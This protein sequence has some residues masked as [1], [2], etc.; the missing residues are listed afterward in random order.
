MTLRL[1]AASGGG[2]DDLPH[3][4]AA[5][6][7]QLIPKQRPMV[8]PPLI[9]STFGVRPNSPTTASRI[10]FSGPGRRG[11]PGILKV[12]GQVPERT[13]AFPLQSSRA[14]RWSVGI[15]ASIPDVDQPRPPPPAG[16]TA[17]SPQ[18][19]L[20]LAVPFAD[21][22][23][24]RD[25]SRPPARCPESNPARPSNS[26]GRSSCALVDPAILVVHHGQGGMDRR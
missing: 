9:R 23:V 25:G 7:Q 16:E 8:A 5:A 19:F 21:F 22:G 6:G 3:L 18:V 26:P 15:P 12:P 2:A 24:I 4:H 20:S 1:F 10:F 11:R 13:C 17:A 14:R